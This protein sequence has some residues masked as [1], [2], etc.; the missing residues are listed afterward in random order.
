MTTLAS[1][2]GDYSEPMGM[3]RR[4]RRRLGIKL[5]KRPGSG[6]R[7]QLRICPKCNSVFLQQCQSCG[8]V[9]G[10]DQTED[11]KNN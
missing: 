8:F 3:M 11:N 5:G 2:V 10:D 7:A 1:D 9:E 6:R 4:G